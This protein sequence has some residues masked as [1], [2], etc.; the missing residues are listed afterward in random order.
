MKLIDE[1]RKQGCF[2]FNTHNAVNNNQLLVTRRPK[3]ISGRKPGDFSVCPKCKGFYSR[4]TMRRHFLKCNPLAARN[5]KNL[6]V[7]SRATFGQIHKKASTIMRKDIIPRMRSDDVTHAISY[8]DL[9]ILYGNK[10]CLKYRKPHLYYMIR[11]KL[12]LIGR[13]LLAIKKKNSQ[14]TDFASIF[15]P[16]FYDDVIFAVSQV[17][18]INE[19]ENAFKSPATAASCG[20]LLKKCG[21][22]LINEY[23]KKNDTPAQS[24][25]KNFLAILE[26]EFQMDIN[27]TVEKSQKEMRRQKTVT[28][29]NI[30]DIKKLNF[31]LNTHRQKYFSNLSEKFDVNVW[32]NLAEFTL[33]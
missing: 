32:R 8:D 24:N 9:A 25:T 18:F 31:Y 30:E 26:E 20:T 17:A 14:V 12:R 15:Q 27:K 4:K 5:D 21:R 16:K 3:L 11:S 23:I 19:E 33:S 28:L 2:Y 1:I 13:L 10:M 7:L 6:G 29:P 22:I